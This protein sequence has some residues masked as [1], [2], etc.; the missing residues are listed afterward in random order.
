MTTYR[1]RLIPALAIFLA[2]VS[3]TANVLAQDIEPRR[4]TH[5]PT[6]INVVGLGTAY[7]SGDIFFDPVLELQDVKTEIYGTG[8]AYIRSFGLAGR[9]AR[10][11]VT[12]PYATARWSGLLSGEPASTRRH[13]FG[14]PRVRFSMLLYGGPALAPSEFASA[15]KSNTV[16][17]AAVSLTVP[18]GEYYPE[19]LIN[20]GSNRWVVRPQLGVT[21]MRGKW[22][23]ELT[24][25]VFLYQ[26]NDDFFDGKRLENDALWALQGHAIYTFRPGFWVSASTAYGN[27]YDTTIDGVDKNLKVDNWLLALSF[28]VPINRQQ[29]LKFYWIG[30][31]TQN[32]T[33]ADLDNF[34]I[35]WTYLF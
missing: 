2:G 28:G 26:D 35:S 4:W 21:H 14:D 16:I 13:G 12:V 11:D 19:K 29:G 6:G 9:S 30:A 18:W 8:L 25:S 34:G 27:G 17:G 5:M 20:L 7:T 33:G 32:R 22:T 3:F 31:R 1:Q 23:W 15:P 24:G 10:V